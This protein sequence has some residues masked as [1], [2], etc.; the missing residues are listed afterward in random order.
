[1]CATTFCPTFRGGLMQIA[2]SMQVNILFFHMSIFTFF[3]CIKIPEDSYTV[4]FTTCT[5]GS[6][7]SYITIRMPPV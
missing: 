3:L 5:R 6:G 4:P 1:M 2:L 7:I